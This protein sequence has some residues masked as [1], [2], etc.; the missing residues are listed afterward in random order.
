MSGGSNR[1]SSDPPR[2][3]LQVSLQFSSVG[4]ALGLDKQ[5]SRSNPFACPG[6]LQAGEVGGWRRPQW[7]PGWS[8][9]SLW[10]DHRNVQST[11]ELAFSLVLLEDLVLNSKTKTNSRDF[12][13]WVYF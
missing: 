8:A 11:E 6:R 2:E 10:R 9:V 5:K 4:A 12:L 13:C 3:P 1:T 7:E